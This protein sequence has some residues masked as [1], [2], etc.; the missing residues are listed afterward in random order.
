[1]TDLPST[2]DLE[3][4]AKAITPGPWDLVSLSGYGSPFSIRMAYTSD[5]PNTSK[6]H[7]G[8]QSVGRGENA[9]AIAL[10]PDLLRELIERRE[11]DAQARAD[12]GIL[13]D[14]IDWLQDCM[15]ETL[16]NEDDAIVAQIRAYWSPTTEGDSH[17]RE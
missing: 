5:Y 6:T 13:L 7:Y 4:L 10:V 17:E 2:E 14:Q 1:M 8:V 3:R 11:A 15:G 12:I 9:R 16:D